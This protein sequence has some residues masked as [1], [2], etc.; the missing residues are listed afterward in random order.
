M[1]INGEDRP[2]SELGEQRYGHS[3]RIHP[4]AESP[5]LIGMFGVAVFISDLM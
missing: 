1:A 2:L 4:D 5:L 3:K